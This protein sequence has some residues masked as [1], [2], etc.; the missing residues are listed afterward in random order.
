MLTGREFLTGPE[1]ARLWGISVETADRWLRRGLVPGAIRT[2]G[3]RGE[4]RVPKLAA[5]ELVASRCT[6]ADPDA[7]AELAAELAR[8]AASW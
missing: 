8:R 5:A 2:L 3:G 7:Q 1:F 4:W 6:P